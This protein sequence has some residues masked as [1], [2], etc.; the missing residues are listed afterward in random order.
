MPG[1]DAGPGSALEVPG[2]RLLHGDNLALMR[3]MAE[4]PGVSGQVALAYMDPPFNTGG[5]FHVGGKNGGRAPSRTPAYRDDEPL[6][7]YLK[8]MQARFEAL[9][10]LLAANASVFVHAD[11]RMVHYL[12]VM[13]DGVFGR[14]RFVNEIIWRYKSGGVARTCFAAKHDTILWYANGPGHVFHADAV[15]VSAARRNHMKRTVNASGEAVRTIRSNGKIYEYPED[16]LAPPCDVW[17]DISHLNQRDPERTGYATQKPEALLERIVLA[18]SNPG[19]LV[20]DPFCGSGTTL[21][22]AKAHGRRWIGID[23]SEAAI[24]IAR[25]RLGVDAP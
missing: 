20:L 24:E 23:A 8:G 1:P 17:D 21:A 10:P 14:G 18:S 12:K 22:V 3:R 5:V 15:G 6:D 16:R 7:E 25:R 4:D 9:R 19:D 11:A 2:S 13:L